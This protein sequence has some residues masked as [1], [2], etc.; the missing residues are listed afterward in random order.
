MAIVALSALPALAI[1]QGY[2]NLDAG[3]PG[4]IEDASPTERHELELQLLSLR[5]EQFASGAQRW[6]TDAKIAY[7]VA[8][9]TEVEL[10]VPL[11]VV[12]PHVPGSPVTAGIGGVAIGGLH[13]LTIETGAI[14]SL[15]V[16][17]EWSAPV[18][19]LAAPVGSY[20]AKLLGSK[21]FSFGRVHANVG[22]GSWSVR[23]SSGGTPGCPSSPAPGQ[24]LPPGCEQAAPPVYIPDTPCDRVPTAALLSCA[25]GAAQ[26]RTA[27]AAVGAPATVGSRWMAAVGADRAFALSSTLVSAGVVAERFIGLY[28]ALDWS[29][30][31][32]VRRQLTPQLVADVG[33]ARHFFGV[34]RSNAI[35][36]GFS[37]GIPLERFRA[38]RGRE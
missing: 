28:D 35:N 33:V 25:A 17:G 13:A 20:S 8:P 14:P 3:R 2:Y 19:D 7:G 12:N 18:G 1:A 10:R 5:F 29:A 4:R 31:I 6:R 27:I 21:S 34:A 38:S 32:G 36:L 16:A 37:Y 9:F 22:Y 15:A 11:L 30:E 23:P 26:V 24:V